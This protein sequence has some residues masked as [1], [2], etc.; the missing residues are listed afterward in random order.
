MKRPLFLTAHSEVAT[1]ERVYCRFNCLC[2]VVTAAEDLVAI[3]KVVANV[4]V[5]FFLWLLISSG[6]C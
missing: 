1:V 6:C 2:E 5:V 3:M 4:N